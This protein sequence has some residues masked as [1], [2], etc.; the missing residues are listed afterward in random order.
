MD[1]FKFIFESII[2][3]LPVLL[4]LKRYNDL[5]LLTDFFIAIVVQSHEKKRFNLFNYGCYLL[6]YFL[7]H[8]VSFNLIKCC[9]VCVMFEILFN[10]FNDMSSFPGLV[11]LFKISQSLKLFDS[12]RLLTIET[13]FAEK[14]LDFFQSII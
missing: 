13:I 3:F 7:P 12:A 2:Y 14:F 4:K 1:D 8:C 6:L 9:D 10:E 5:I 11:Y